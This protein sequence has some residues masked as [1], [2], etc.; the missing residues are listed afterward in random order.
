[1]SWE[2][3]ARFYDQFATLLDS[4]LPLP[5]AIELAGDV[6]GGALKTRAARVAAD[7]AR[8]RGVAESLTAAGEGPL[9]VA[10]VHAGEAAGALPETCR[11]ISAIYSE[12]HTTRGQIIGRLIY[13]LILLH[14][15]MVI[16]ALP[17]VVLGT[18]DPLWL[19]AGPVTL[20]TLI[21]IAAIV[22][23]VTAANGL[24]A[25]LAL[26]WPLSGLTMPL[27]TA[28]SC[29]ALR[30]TLGAGL[31]VQEAFTLAAAACGNRVMAERLRRAGADLEAHRQPSITA[32]LT[33]CGWNQAL[34]ALIAAGEAGGSTDRALDQA[35]IAAR[36]QFSWRL[37]WTARAFTSTVYTIAM[38]MAVAAIVGMYQATYGA[39]LQEAAKDLE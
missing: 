32:A 5:R 19:V 37:Q 28:N 16:P 31:R 38:L 17:G 27:I 21:V 15:A 33:A 18:S 30:A 23:R 20:W 39:A 4:G 3:T 13:P 10:L 35:G 14:A 9:A 34:I 22:I 12:W 24:G 29:T 25:R 2:R 7:C 1:M 8:G 36:E 11:R 6:A 26:S